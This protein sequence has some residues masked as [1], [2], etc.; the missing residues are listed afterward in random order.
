M[1]GGQQNSVKNLY[2]QSHLTDPKLFRCIDFL[3]FFDRYMLY[4]MVANIP[5]T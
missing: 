2:S 4:E 1:P 5:K 3:H